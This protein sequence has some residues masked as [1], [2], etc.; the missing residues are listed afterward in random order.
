MLQIISLSLFFLDFTYGYF[1]TL[2]NISYQKMYCQVYWLFIAY[3]YWVILRNHFPTQIIREELISFSVC[4]HIDVCLCIYEY[5]FICLMHLGFIL[6][7]GLKYVSKFIIFPDSYPFAPFIKTSTFIQWS[8]LSLLSY[9][10]FSY[11][12]ES[13]S[14]CSILFH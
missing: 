5:M 8:Q 3:V 9:T 12:L 13:I 1:F 4:M 10:K 11:V 2:K 7:Y 6:M 14:R